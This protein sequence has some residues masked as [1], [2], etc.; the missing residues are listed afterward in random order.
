MQNNNEIIAIYKYAFFNVFS[1]KMN[2][3][4]IVL[5]IQSNDDY[6]L[7]CLCFQLTVLI[8]NFIFVFV[9]DPIIN[10]KSRAS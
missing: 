10:S 9:T 1:N 7:C 3:V 6:T 5:F 4:D 2:Y 8:I